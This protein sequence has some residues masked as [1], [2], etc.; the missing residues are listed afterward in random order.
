MTAELTTLESLVRWAKFWGS[1]DE[2]TACF[3]CPIFCNAH[4]FNL[5]EAWDAVVREQGRTKLRSDGRW[6]VS[7]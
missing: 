5:N 1:V 7:T 3:D 4:C 6:A 2:W